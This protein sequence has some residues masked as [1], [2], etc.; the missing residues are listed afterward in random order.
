MVAQATPGTQFNVGGILLN[1]P[2]KIR[3]LGHFG[4]NV[5]DITERL[6]FYTELLG[7]PH[8][9][10]AGLLRGARAPANWTGWA[11]RRATSPATAATT[12]PSCCSTAA[13]GRRWT[14][15]GGSS[16]R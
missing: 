14:R 3:R 16:P 8:L 4:F 7:L 1:Q 9:R 10:R 15:S 6:R 13:C 5:V 2:F 11:I 12:T